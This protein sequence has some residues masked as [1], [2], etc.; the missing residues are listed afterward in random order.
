ML[1]RKQDDLLKR[2]EALN[3]KLQ[4]LYT[5][6]QRTQNEQEIVAKDLLE[7]YNFLK[8]INEKNERNL[9]GDTENGTNN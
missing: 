2:T 5:E 3:D 1:K 4:G 7:T 8:D 9:K 6:I